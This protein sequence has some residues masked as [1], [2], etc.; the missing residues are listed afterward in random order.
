MTMQGPKAT[1]MVLERFD[2]KQYF[3]QYFT[4]EDSLDRA[5]QLELRARGDAGKKASSMFVGDRLNDLNAAKRVGMPFTMIRTHGEDP[6]DDDVPVYHS[7]AE[8]LDAV[9]LAVRSPPSLPRI[10]SCSV[11]FAA[12]TTLNLSLTLIAGLSG[13]PRPSLKIAPAC[14]QSG[15]P[16]ARSMTLILPLTS[17]KPSILP[18]AMK[19]ASRALRAEVDLPP[20]RRYQLGDAPDDGQRRLRDVDPDDGLLQLAA[21]R[22]SLFGRRSSSSGRPPRSSRCR[23]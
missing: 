16:A 8:F 21:R 20:D 10:R 19:H 23:R 1:E 15:T 5:E 12:P 22:S 13:P 9:G 11:R 2:L 14:R 18:S 4:R 6:E 3:V 17:T 7:V